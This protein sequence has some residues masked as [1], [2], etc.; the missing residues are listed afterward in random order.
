M[1]KVKLLSN[2]PEIRERVKKLMQADLDIIDF[3]SQNKNESDELIELTNLDISN[4]VNAVMIDYGRYLEQNG[5]EQNINAYEEFIK[6][7]N[8]NNKWVECYECD[9]LL[10]MED[11]E[12]LVV[13]NIVTTDLDILND[14]IADGCYT[15]KEDAKY[16]Y[17]KE[18]EKYKIV[19]S[20]NRVWYVECV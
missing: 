2:S 10:D 13:N 6:N 12:Y 8:P 7:Y 16:Y 18:Q 9:F 14:Y 4:K 20:L 17:N 1:C 5:L 3:S 11:V 19:D 15:F